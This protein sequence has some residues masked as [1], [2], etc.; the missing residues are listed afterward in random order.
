MQADKKIAIIGGGLSGLSLGYFL[1]KENIPF[2]LFTKKENHSSI[3]AAGVINPIVFRRT[4]KS[5]EVDTF[6]PF[7]KRFY[8]E[9]ETLINKNIW[10]ELV[11]RRSFSHQQEQD[12]WVAKK[13]KQEYAPYLG[14]INSPSPENLFTEYGTGIVK[15]GAWIN[16]TN[17]IYGLRDFLEEKGCL[18]YTNGKEILNQEEYAKIVYCEG[19][20][21]IHNAFFN[22]LPLDPT[23]GQTLIIQSEEIPTGELINRKCFVLPSGGNEFRVGA[24]YEWHDASLHIT[25]E[26]KNAL[27]ED[28][29]NLIQAKF[30]ILEQ[31]AGVRPTVKDRRPLMGQHPTNKALYV[32]N[33]LGAKGYLIGPY[34]A[35][36]MS[37]F[38]I[39]EKPLMKEVDISRY[40]NLWEEK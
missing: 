40:A 21:M 27:E 6:L 18:T 30:S 17:F 2:K 5:W 11:I 38:L 34:M 14:E 26:S 29:K 32:F 12:D 4:T 39:H 8:K 7:A 23:K 33:G 15:Q 31:K 35:S 19:Y 37:A 13:Q 24:T 25:E 3:I 28:V 36:E 10:N 9:I 20:E 16:T 22:Y 1:W